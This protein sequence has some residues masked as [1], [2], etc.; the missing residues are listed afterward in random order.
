MDI[1]LVINV[2]LLTLLLVTAIILLR[3]QNIL[4][5]V[6]LSGIYSLLSAGFFVT[7]DAVDVAFTEAA[8]GS[9]AMLFALSS[10]SF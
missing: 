1:Q 5:V 7:L 8:V 6:L 4:A 10:H 9:E 2:S 3:L